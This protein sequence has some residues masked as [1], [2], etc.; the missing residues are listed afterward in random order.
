VKVRLPP[1][2]TRASRTV[3]AKEVIRCPS[4]GSYRLVPEIAFIGGAK[5]LCQDCG[6]RGSF[7]VTGMGRGGGS[8]PGGA[9]P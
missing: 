2:T 4:C 8:P 5:Y 1:G 7:V 3:P 9:P 6:F